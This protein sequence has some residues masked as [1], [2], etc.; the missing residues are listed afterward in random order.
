M[1]PQKPAIRGLF[2][3]GASM[4]DSLKTDSS[5]K[6]NRAESYRNSNHRLCRTTKN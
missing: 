5:S 6:P 1:N 4:F 2:Y 3:W